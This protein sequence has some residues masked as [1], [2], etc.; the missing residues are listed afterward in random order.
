MK[1]PNL[2]AI[3]GTFL[4][5]LG[6]IL[7][8]RPIIDPDYY[9]HVRVGDLIRTTGHL[10]T[11]DVFSWMAAGHAWIDQEWGSNTIL[12]FLAAAS[13]YIGPALFF[14]ILMFLLFGLAWYAM[15]IA[16]S[17]PAQPI[18]RGFMLLVIGAAGAPNLLA[19][20]QLFD[21]FFVLFALV[22]LLAYR[23]FGQTRLLLVMPLAMIFWVNL[24]GG[25]VPAYFLVVVA[26][27][28]G[29]WLDKRLGWSEPETRR[30]WTPIALSIAATTLAIA[31]NPQGPAIYAYALPTIFSNEAG[32][33]I[34]E[35]FSPDFHD[36]MNFGLL[37]Y[38]G[39][40]LFVLATAR[41]R[42]MATILLVA[43]FC[44][45]ALFSIRYVGFFVPVS[46]VVL[47]PYVAILYR[48]SGRV[49]DF[50]EG[51][52]I[53]RPT[54]VILS[55]VTIVALVARIV[56]V[57]IPGTLQEQSTRSLYPVEAV[58]WLATHPHGRIFNDYT[59]GGYII[60]RTG[61]QVAI[62]GAGETL[63]DNVLRQYRQVS[64]LETDPMTFFIAHD[65][66]TV[67]VQS[68]SPLATY[69]HER[70]DWWIADETGGAV[71]FVR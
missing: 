27:G 33:L 6:L 59:W 66:R 31:V 52:R 2:G 71:I 30:S 7:V 28:V 24:H 50:V 47:S 51:A 32:R 40:N 45:M 9:W 53:S 46:A 15:G 25:G 12:S 4:A 64:T 55:G 16:G 60:W 39:F 42:E 49:A 57:V 26:C 43:G 18:V 34:N 17:E 48:R 56:M 63:G 1:R 41:I 58:E 11:V 67:I 10:P 54:I 38:L 35:W 22:G 14:A 68:G 62:Y 21:S 65:V 61:E 20:P 44:M 5:V 29:W 37:A 13:G 3:G 23:R 8:L 19:R 69:L 36:P 70:S